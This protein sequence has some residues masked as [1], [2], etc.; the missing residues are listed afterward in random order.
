MAT[1]APKGRLHTVGAVL[2]PMTIPA[3]SL[4]GGE[5]TVDG[6]PLGSPAL[7]KT[8]LDFCVR[9]DIYPTVEEYAMKDV[10]EAMEQLEKGKAR[11]RI[12]LKN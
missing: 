9:H 3:F 7:S 11:Y 2:E 12:V 5:K 4:T 8:K 10:N 1:L 6:S